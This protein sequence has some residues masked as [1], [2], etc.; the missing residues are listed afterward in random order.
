MTREK[1]PG[2]INRLTP[3][4]SKIADIGI[5]SSISLKNGLDNFYEWF[6]ETVESEE[7]K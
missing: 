2:D 7:L 3:D 6:I 5:E 4:V 1:K